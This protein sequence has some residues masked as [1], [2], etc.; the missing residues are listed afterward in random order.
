[1]RT[2]IRVIDSI[3]EYTGRTVLWLCVVLIFVLA[4]E[5]TA[6][7]VFNAPTNWAMET[8]E[9]LGATIAVMGW[10]YTHRHHGHIRVDVF[11]ARL[12]PRGKAI[13]DV[14]CSVLFLFPLLAILIYTSATWMWFSWKMNEKLI[15][16]NWLPPA[17]PIKTVVLLGVCLFALQ[18]LAQFIRD[19]YLLIRNKPL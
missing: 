2:I 18:A 15:E 17:G 14:T 16:S 11:Y 3:S 13:V 4:Y 19:F 7:Y 8:G 10:S 12:S 5:T 1:M 9:M 6:R